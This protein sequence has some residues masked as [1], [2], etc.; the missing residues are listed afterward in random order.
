ME[1][2]ANGQ[3]GLDVWE[4]LVMVRGHEV[5]HVTLLHLPMGELLAL[6][7]QLRQK[8]VLNFRHAHSQVS[9]SFNIMSSK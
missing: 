2:G 3:C 8:I 9:N 7:L 4:D 1:D 5:G 6:A